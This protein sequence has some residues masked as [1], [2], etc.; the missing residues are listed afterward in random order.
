MAYH[1]IEVGEAIRE[2]E[3]GVGGEEEGR[4]KATELKAEAAKVICLWW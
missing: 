2:K 3:A 1:F 4:E